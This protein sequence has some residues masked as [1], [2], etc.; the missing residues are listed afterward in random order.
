MIR[1]AS[2]RNTADVRVD[3]DCHL[4]CVRSHNSS[5]DYGAAGG[6]FIVD[7]GAHTQT[8][9]SASSSSRHDSIGYYI[10]LDATHNFVGLCTLSL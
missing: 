4:P 7:F 3:A 8:Q 10:P 5:K 9:T 2:E 6:Q 1:D